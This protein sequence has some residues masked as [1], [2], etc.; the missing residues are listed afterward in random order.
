MSALSNIYALTTQSGENKKNTKTN[1]SISSESPLNPNEK[2]DHKPTFLL[3]ITWGNHLLS[4][5]VRSIF[6]KTRIQ[7]WTLCHVVRNI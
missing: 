1:S 4:L 5:K 3:M 2:N 6:M 7:G